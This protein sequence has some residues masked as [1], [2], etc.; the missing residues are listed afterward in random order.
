[1]QTITSRLQ[2]NIDSINDWYK[3]NHL[4]I[5]VDK[6]KSILLQTRSHD[7]LKIYIDGFEIEQVKSI[8]Y[9]GVEIHEN[10]KW[11]IHVNNLCKSIGYKI[12]SLGKLRKF[13]SS[14]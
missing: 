13:L 12:R 4:R 1:M 10:L 3:Q 8:R 9:L 6:T 5:N 7:I 14:S 2:S 11:D